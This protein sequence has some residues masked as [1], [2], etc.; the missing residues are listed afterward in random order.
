MLNDAKSAR[1]H[2]NSERPL[3]FA[4]SGLLDEAAARRGKGRDGL[5]MFLASVIYF[6]LRFSE[7]LTAGRFEPNPQS[8]NNNQLT[9]SMHIK[10]VP[11]TPS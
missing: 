8:N 10:K 11:P 6:R 3:R 2:P 9:V 4:P 7:T 1:R 5:R